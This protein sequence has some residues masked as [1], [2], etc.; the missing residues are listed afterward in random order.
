MDIVIIFN[1]LGNQMSQYAFYLQKK[2]IANNTQFLFEKKSSKV[3]NGFELENVFGIKNKE[4][5]LTR[6]LY[7]IYRI[8]SYKKYPFFTRPMIH[9]LGFLGIKVVYENQEYDFNPKHMKKSWGLV[10]YVGGWHAEKYFYDVKSQ[11][12][13]YYKFNEAGLNLANQEALN[14]ILQGNSVSVHVRRGDFLNAEN[15]HVFGSVCTKAYYELAINSIKEKVENPIFYFFTNDVPWVRENFIGENYKIVEIN[16]GKTS[17]CDMFLISK[18]KYHINSNGTF[19]WWSSWLDQ[20]K[21][22]VVIVPERF[23]AY[24]LFKDIYPDT[25]I[26]LSGY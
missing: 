21:D 20:K 24:K 22:S 2:N 15:Y 13:E 14:H 3:H 4:G 9:L 26:K 19:S 7:L 8:A 1:G 17:W 10:F 12:L 25:W 6:L 18:C 5:F 11:V 23:V 16:T